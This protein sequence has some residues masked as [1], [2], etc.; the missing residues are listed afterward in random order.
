MSSVASR[1]FSST[2][3]KNALKRLGAT[4]ADIKAQNPGKD[5]GPVL[6]AINRIEA[7]A[8][9]R[10]G[11]KAAVLRIQGAKLHKSTKDQTEALEVITISIETEKGTRL[12]SDHAREDGTS[13]Q[14]LTRAGGG[15]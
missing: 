8:E 7:D 12:E 4:V 6:N 1:A 15:K 10:H 11:S 3:G 9:K 5:V 14:K 13:S 2:S